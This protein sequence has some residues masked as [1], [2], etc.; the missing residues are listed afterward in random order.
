MDEATR[1][2]LIGLA[3]LLRER[4]DVAERISNLIHRPAQIGHVGEFIA[5]RIFNIQLESA[6]N[7]KAIDGTFQEGALVGKTVNV[8]FYAKLESLLDIRAA[9]PPDYFLVFTGPKAT[10]MTSRGEARLWHIESV[11]LFDGHCLQQELIKRGVKLCEATS[12]RNHQWHA[13]EIYPQPR[14][15][16]F[17]L[18]ENQ[19]QVLRL[20]GQTQQAR[21]IGPSCATIQA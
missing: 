2:E 18:S 3:Q 12:I 9:K 19:K 15:P 16:L 14:N 7:A 6:A 21:P 4:N 1:Q 13:A 8:K 17:V 10:T 20:F 11:F 5:S